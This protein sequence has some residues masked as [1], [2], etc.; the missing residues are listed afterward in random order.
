SDHCNDRSLCPARIENQADGYLHVNDEDVCHAEDTRGTARFSLRG[1][2][3]CAREARRLHSRTRCGVRATTVLPDLR[4]TWPLFA[5]IPSVAEPSL[6]FFVSPT[7]HPSRNSSLRGRARRRM[8]ERVMEMLET[9]WINRAFD[10]DRLPP[11][12]R[13]RSACDDA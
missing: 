3:G 12:S 8:A 6:L 11:L 9:R 5:R 4:T 7:A 2:P 1:G 10:A 13:S